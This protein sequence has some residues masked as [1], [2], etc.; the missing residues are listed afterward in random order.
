MFEKAVGRNAIE[1]CVA[2]GQCIGVGGEEPT[3][4]MSLPGQDE[5]AHRNVDSPDVD[6]API[7]G[8]HERSRPAADFQD[9]GIRREERGEY[10][11]SD[12]GSFLMR[13]IELATTAIH[14]VRHPVVSAD[15]VGK[16]A[17]RRFVV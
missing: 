16:A 12:L 5:P 6:P 15:G 8:L 13:E 9:A 11:S 2:P 14:V 1:R 17:L 10:L 3:R 4:G 7:G